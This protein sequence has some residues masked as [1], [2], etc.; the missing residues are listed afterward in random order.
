MN[1]MEKKVYNAPVLTVVSF[2][3]EKGFATSIP[4]PTQISNVYLGFDEMTLPQD[5]Q[6]ME[7]YTTHNG[8]A[9]PGFG[10]G[11]MGNNSFF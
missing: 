8:W 4:D 1:N 11:A 3:V 10:S 6:P 7:Q 5:Q 2:K 9:D